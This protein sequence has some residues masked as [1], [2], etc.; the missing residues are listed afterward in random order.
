MFRNWIFLRGQRIF[1]ANEEDRSG[2]LRTGCSCAMRAIETLDAR[3][4]VQVLPLVA[5][6]QVCGPRLLP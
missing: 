6:R 5:T 2:L 1:G 4:R 3:A